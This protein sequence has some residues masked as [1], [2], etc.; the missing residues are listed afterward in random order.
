MTKKVNGEKNIK[1][2][3]DLSYLVTRE[4]ET[5]PPFSGILNNEKRK[6]TY[7]CINCGNLLFLSDSKFDSYSGWPSFFRVANLKSVNEKIDDSHGMIRTE[8]QCYSC[9]SHLGHVFSDGP[10]PTGLRYCINSVALKF[11]CDE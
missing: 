5:E 9:K 2:R 11:S 1:Y 10:N 4:G 8:V 6:G 3:N 7:N